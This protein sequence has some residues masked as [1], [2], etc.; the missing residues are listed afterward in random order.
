MR[1]AFTFLSIFLS[2][3]S[4]LHAE[5]VELF[6]SKV[7]R[8]NLEIATQGTII[9]A[10][11]A[12][13]KGFSLKAPMIGVAQMRNLEG[14]SYAL[15]VQQEVPLSSR[16]SKDKKSREDSYE[17]QK[18]ESEYFT[19][20]KMLEARLAFISYWKN[21]EKIKYTE[22]IRNWL[23]QHAEYI[24]SVVRSDAATNVYALEIQ[25]YIGLLENEVSSMKGMLETEKAKL[26]ELSFDETY[27]PG[28]PTLD[29]LKPL[30][31][32]SLSSR[33]SSINLSKLRVASSKLE[34]AQTSLMPNLFLKARKLDRLMVGMANQEIM[35]GIDLPFAYFWQPRAEKA[36]A[37]ANKYMAEA[38]Y[39]KSEVQSEALKHALKEKASILNNQIKTLNEVSV[40]A[41]EKALKYAKNIAPRDMSGLETHRRIFQD[42]IELK[43][44][45]LEIRMNYEEIYS[46]WSLVFAQGNL[47][48]I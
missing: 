46:N 9:S 4:V 20:E 30:P 32:A 21:F 36:E 38:N 12:R 23:K 7:K 14:V 10:A 41:A 39:R 5:S 15:E 33:I 42:Y 2:V 19:R 40:P 16:L 3:I 44:Q 43:S 45:L 31:E 6:L 11:E 34:V 24:R 22:E 35:V 48:E 1:I 29:D 8:K 17:L 13:S 18:K 37:V 47:H 26:K 27:D 25:S 28:V